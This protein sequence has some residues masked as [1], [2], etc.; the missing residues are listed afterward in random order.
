M[1]RSDFYYSLC[2]WE[3]EFSVWE[4][5]DTDIRPEENVPLV[6]GIRSD[7]SPASLRFRMF[8]SYDFET[9]S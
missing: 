2:P 7:F 3:P 6:S 5:G 4:T 1:G 9:L 8:G